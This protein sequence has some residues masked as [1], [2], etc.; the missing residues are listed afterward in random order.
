MALSPRAKK[1]YELDKQLGCF[2][3]SEDQDIVRKA[4]EN[5]KGRTDLDDKEKE[6]MEIRN[7][8]QEEYKNKVSE[9]AKLEDALKEAVESRSNDVEEMRVSYESELGARNI[10]I[11]E[12]RR[13][14][15]E[16]MGTKEE[17]L[18]SAEK[19]M[20]S[21]LRAKDAEVT[22]LRIWLDE[23]KN[24][25]AQGREVLS[26]YQKRV[27][28][29]EMEIE[30]LKKSKEETVKHLEQKIAKLQ[31]LF[32]EAIADKNKDSENTKVVF[33]SVVEEKERQIAMLKESSVNELMTK[34]EGSRRKDTQI[35]ELSARLL[36][37]ETQLTK[38]WVDEGNNDDLKTKITSLLKKMKDLKAEKGFLEKDFAA[39]VSDIRAKENKLD[40]IQAKYDSESQKKQ[41]LQQEFDSL[42]HDLENWKS[43]MKLIEVERNS[44]EKDAKRLRDDLETKSS[45]A[46]ELECKVQSLE[47]LRQNLEEVIRQLRE[48]NV[49]SCQ[50]QRSLEFAIREKN[51]EHKLLKEKLKISETKL[52]LEVEHKAVIEKNARATIENTRNKYEEL[53]KGNEELKIHLDERENDVASLT[54]LL[55]DA[56]RK[57]DKLEAEIEQLSEEFEL[58]N[59][60]HTRDKSEKE[61]LERSL[62]HA[63]TLKEQ[64]LVELQ[65]KFEKSIIEQ[66]CEIEKREEYWKE[67]M[68]AKDDLVKDARRSFEERVMW[69]EDEIQKLDKVCE[70]TRIEFQLVKESLGR[71]LTSKEEEISLLRKT[72]GEKLKEK[73]ETI[74]EVTAANKDILQ[75]RDELKEAF[76]EC[77]TRLDDVTQTTHLQDSEIILTKEKMLQLESN[78]REKEELLRNA[79]K[80]IEDLKARLQEQEENCV[81][82]IKNI[83]QSAE[84]GFKERE[85]VAEKLKTVIQKNAVK[86]Q[87]SLQGKEDKISALK[88]KLENSNKDAEDMRVNL[89]SFIQESGENEINLNRDLKIV[90][91]ECRSLE[92]KIFELKKALENRDKELEMMENNLVNAASDFEK[93]QKLKVEEIE[94]VEADLSNERIK[95]Q[96]LEE[97]L[98]WLKVQVDLKDQNLKEITETSETSER[99]LEE[100]LIDLSRLRDNFNE[101]EDL[102]KLTESEKVCAEGVKQNLLQEL[103][104]RKRSADEKDGKIAVLLH[105]IKVLKKSHFET[106][107]KQEKLEENVATL[108]IRFNEKDTEMNE[109]KAERESKAEEFYERSVLLEEME[110]KRDELEKNVTELQET[111]RVQKTETEEAVKREEELKGAVQDLFAKLKDNELNTM[112]LVSKVEDGK[113]ENEKLRSEYENLK[114]SSMT[115]NRDLNEEISHLHCELDKQGQLLRMLGKEKEVLLTDLGK[116]KQA[117]QS[118]RTTMECH[119]K[120]LRKDNASLEEK[121]ICLDEESKR[122]FAEI[123]EINSALSSAE[124]TK[125]FLT[126]EV[127]SLKISVSEKEDSLRNAQKSLDAV[128]KE[129]SRLKYETKSLEVNLA[130]AINEK[131]NVVKSL[132]EFKS[133]S[134]H[135]KQ[136]LEDV[137]SEKEKTITSA[138]NVIRQLKQ[139]HGALKSQ[140]FK[141]EREMEADKKCVVDLLKKQRELSSEIE[142]LNKD[143]KILEASLKDMDLYPVKLKTTQGKRFP[144]IF[145][146]LITTH[147]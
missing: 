10:E 55:E 43:T 95:V 45:C 73:E 16:L 146:Y 64:E 47:S 88:R 71:S 147:N 84:K 125:E 91:G 60:K 94:R 72:F 129:K 56:K 96:E 51:R 138:E 25:N 116:T 86:Y 62:T 87:Q 141:C 69:K 81:T 90:E 113:V 31:V 24:S 40:D 136:K 34:E 29:K 114:T 110:L 23:A 13:T 36:W 82:Q 102:L 49:D 100:T 4:R 140:V 66:K 27:A 137:L 115:E 17:L 5:S 134:S 132:E 80:E 42:T 145:L 144:N 2:P 12:L 107:K 50:A 101:V 98:S 127:E 118:T 99:K 79:D 76:E 26:S 74:A 119:I 139:D 37:V 67:A 117:E 61:A 78:L 143:K 68:K 35:E 8:W 123:A 15:D 112:A 48:E 142:A 130:R 1:R 131:D 53:Q 120:S 54:R 38:E 85:N 124:V 9:V 6:L 19:S 33:D 21:K 32:S 3:R 108:Q 22:R 104:R 7:Y 75:R 44:L 57:E 30:A 63:V 14:L 89:A 105:K 93:K 97:R 77:K 106:A 103:E 70:D 59:E 121:I 109:L 122:R 28:D 133:S 83:I 65:E 52:A 18:A 46:C 20:E 11:V 135:S 128:Q 126:R 39:L 58:L 41:I 92:D 111:V